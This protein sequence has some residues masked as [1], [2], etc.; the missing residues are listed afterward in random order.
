MNKDAVQA[1]KDSRWA[2]GAIY[3][4]KELLSAEEEKYGTLGYNLIF[5]YVKLSDYQKAKSALKNYGEWITEKDRKD[6]REELEKIKPESEAD[7]QE[8]KMTSDGQIKKLGFFKSQTT[9]NDVIGLERMKKQLKAKIV[10]PI[11]R[12]D[13]YRE[14]GAKLSAGAI[15]YGPPGSGKTFLA[16]AIAG[17]ASGSML[18]VK[19][20][21]VINKYFGGTEKNIKTIFQTAREN[22]PAII[23]LDEMDGIAQDRSDGGD[24]GFGA[25][26]KSLIGTML[27]ELDGI[28]KNNDGI[29]LIGATNLP[30][31]IDPAFKRPGRFGEKIYI[32]PPKLNDRTA[33]FKYY[34]A[35]LYKAKLDYLKLGLA[36]FGFTPNDIMAVC[37]S[38]AKNKASDE[39]DG[40]PRRPIANYDILREIKA[41]GK[42]LL[43]EWYAKALKE[44]RKM[45]AEER[46]QYR[47]LK[48]DIIYW[49]KGA[50]SEYRTQQFFS[51]IL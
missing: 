26:M 49:N 30:W 34:T 36:S 1:L 27:D 31:S 17:S 10:N 25:A 15:L 6:I 19:I 38:A 18:L 7:G 16:S 22:K 5:C 8:T 41:V 32:G 43:F 51:N 2:D 35:K 45:P 50:K 39:I 28:Q 13:V 29:Y 3:I 24:I 47:E 44:F 40:K 4:K 21:E 14:Y 48:K 37:D 9:L 12:P 42:P 46:N 23:F 20:P 33:L 11:L